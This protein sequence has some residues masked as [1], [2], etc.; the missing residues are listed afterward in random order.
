MCICLLDSLGGGFT[1][2]RLEQFQLFHFC[3]AREPLS[4]IFKVALLAG[5]Y[6]LVCV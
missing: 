4:A 1:S 6:K 5:F 2:L 3:F